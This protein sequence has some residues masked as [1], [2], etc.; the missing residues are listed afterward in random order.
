MDL[1]ARIKGNG[2]QFTAFDFKPNEP[3]V[4][5]VTLE[6][7]KGDNVVR[8]ILAAWVRDATISNADPARIA[9]KRTADNPSHKPAL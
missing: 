2:L 1:A 7:P 5:R 4:D 6:S 8:A 9:P 3:G